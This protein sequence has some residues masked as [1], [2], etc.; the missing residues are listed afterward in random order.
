[1]ARKPEVTRHITYTDCVCRCFAPTGERVFGKHVY[2][3]R[4]VRDHK[5]RTE[6]C[7]QA[8]A[9]EGYHLLQIEIV[10]YKESFAVQSEV[11]FLQNAH[12]ISTREIIFDN[13]SKKNERK[14]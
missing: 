6:K 5:K 1:M 7:R 8:L 10:R 3:P 4:I 11:E 14:N 12:I 13:E 9:K 2:L